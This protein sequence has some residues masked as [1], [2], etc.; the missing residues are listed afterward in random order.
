MYKKKRLIPLLI[1][2]VMSVMFILYNEGLNQKFVNEKAESIVIKRSNWQLRTTEFY[3]QNG[4]R[5]DSTY[6]N[7]FDLKIGDSISKK[8]NTRRFKVYRKNNSGK[9]QFL[10]NLIST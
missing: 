2:I 10:Y 8:S 5:I 1:L 6:K 4:L 3:L 9:Y 7:K